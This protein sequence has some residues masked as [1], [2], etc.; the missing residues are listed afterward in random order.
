LGLTGQ[1][2]AADTVKVAVVDEQAVV[3]KTAAGKRTLETLKEFSVS[4]QRILAA[5]GEEMQGLEKDLRDSPPNLSDAAKKEKQ[6]RFR[7]KY[8]GY[9]RRIQDFQREIE[10]KQKELDAEYQTKIKAVVADVAQKQGFVAVLGKG[11]E[12]TMKIV[13][14]AQ[15]AFDLTEA[16]IKEFDRRYK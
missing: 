15:P 9:Q 4:R 13:I 5:E 7:I 8:E 12:N 1:G 16:V 11:G 10:T 3:E 2:Q 14:Y 6:E